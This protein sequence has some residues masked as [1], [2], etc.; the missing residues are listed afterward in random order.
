MRS[1]Y[2]SEYIQSGCD[3]LLYDEEENVD[4]SIGTWSTNYAIFAVG[5]FF[6]IKLASCPP[7][8]RN[9]SFD[10][11]DDAHENPKGGAGFG[12]NVEDLRKKNK[13]FNIYLILF[14]AMMALSFGVAGIGH[15]I[16][17]TRSSATRIPMEVTS[18]LLFDFGNIALMAAHVI[19]DD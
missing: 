7:F 12:D 2:D 9:T 10:T 1:L 8:Q 18:Y 13:R 19:R 4:N 11:G 15:Q 3:P 17:T 6:V 5:L 16:A 14:F